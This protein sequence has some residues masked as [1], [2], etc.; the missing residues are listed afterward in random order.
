MREKES[1]VSAWE[2]SSRCSKQ[3]TPGSWDEDTFGK[4]MELKKVCEG[5]LKQDK[6]LPL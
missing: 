5:W 1:T 6:G 3:L 4:F 2:K